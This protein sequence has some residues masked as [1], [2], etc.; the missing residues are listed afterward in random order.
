MSSTAENKLSQESQLVYKD[1]KD[2]IMALQLSIAW[3]MGEMCPEKSKDWLET[4]IQQ[5]DK[6]SDLSVVV[7]GLKEI[8]EDLDE[9]TKLKHLGRDE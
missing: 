4:Q 1:L 3:L 2:Q 7:I 8:A 9:I 5:L 6:S